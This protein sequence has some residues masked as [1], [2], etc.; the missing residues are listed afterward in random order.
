[1]SGP[2]LVFST[3]SYDYL[4]AAIAAGE[5]FER[6]E[7][8]RRS[9][10]DGERYRRLLTSCQGRDI[11]IVGGTISDA[12]TLEI[13]DLACAAV[14]YGARCLDLV[15]PYFGYSTMERAVHPGE[16]VTAKSRARLLSSI[17][18]A[19]MGN[20]VYLVDLHVEGLTHYFEGDLHPVHVYAKDIVVAAAR[21]LG[22]DDLVLACT[23]AG[24]AKWV[25]SLA[26]DLAA[27]VAFVYKRR[28]DGSET[29]VT[30]VSAQ[31]EGRTVVIYDDMIRTGGSLLGAADAYLEA[32]AERIYAISTHG[33][34]C[35]EALDRIA[36]SGL[37]AGVA[38][39]DTHPSA[40]ALA[41]DFLAVD[42]VAPLLAARL[43][44]GAGG[45][46]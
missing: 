6:G 11:A 46:P 44:E 45:R 34:F 32:G 5:G 27:D 4:A 41:G 35:A 12:D 13:Y 1:M 38:C 37:I 39:T 26:F 14:Y 19:A 8:E 42:S 40:V 18:S 17:P 10:P 22:G 2:T 23:D 3:A 16:V 7:I 9:F 28:V 30:G 31:V 36:A 29:E 15:I 25:V 33:V 20:R 24:R 21:R 43:R